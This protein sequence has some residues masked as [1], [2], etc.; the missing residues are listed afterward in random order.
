VSGHSSF[1]AAA[2]EVLRRFTGSELFGASYTKA[3]RSLALDPALPGQPVTLQW[4]TFSAAADQAGPSRIYGGIHFENANVA[5]QEL[6]R[7]VGA[8]AFAKAQAYWLGQA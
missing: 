4:A 3:P 7:K 5:G 2:A 1:S 8:L 6:G